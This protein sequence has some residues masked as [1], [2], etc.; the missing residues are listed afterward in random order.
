MKESSCWLFQ[1]LRRDHFQLASAGPGVV[2]RPSFS[3][4]LRVVCSSMCP[5][6][7]RGR[8]GLVLV[9]Q[10]C[11]G[12]NLSALLQREG[13]LPEALSKLYTAEADMSFF[14]PTG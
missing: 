5:G 1:A 8:K 9:L 11:P 7:K 4:D 12:G 10:Y 2:P 13:H 6:F 3:L 14:L